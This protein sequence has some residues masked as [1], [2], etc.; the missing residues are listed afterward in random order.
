MTHRHPFVW[1]NAVRFIAE[2]K[3]AVHV[4]TFIKS[5]PPE[6]FC[7]RSEFPIFLYQI[8]VDWLFFPFRVFVNKLSINML[9]MI[10]ELGIKQ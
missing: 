1:H 3:A 4:I 10:L 8:I 5:D 9:C 7:P 6:H 2:E